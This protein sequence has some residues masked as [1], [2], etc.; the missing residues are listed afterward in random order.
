MSIKKEV[1]VSGENGNLSDLGSINFLFVDHD[2][3]LSVIEFLSFIGVGIK[4][5]L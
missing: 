5:Q 1:L 3:R 2:K 4:S